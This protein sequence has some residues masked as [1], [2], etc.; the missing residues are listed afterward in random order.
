M[1]KKF[2]PLYSVGGIFNNLIGNYAT[3]SKKIIGIDL[4][5]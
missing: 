4:G 1:L 3:F 5:F 2:L